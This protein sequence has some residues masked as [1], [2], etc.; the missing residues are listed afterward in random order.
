MAQY[1]WADGA[2]GRENDQGKITIQIRRKLHDVLV[3]PMLKCVH[4]QES[5][6][7]SACHFASA[8]LKKWEGVIHTMLEPESDEGSV[9]H[10]NISADISECERVLFMLLISLL[11]LEIG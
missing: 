9:V 4:C 10:Q 6:G 8:W 3:F 2:E 7:A 11:A 5:G 1:A